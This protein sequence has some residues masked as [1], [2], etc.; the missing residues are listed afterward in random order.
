MG[1]EGAPFLVDF[2]PRAKRL[3]ADMIVVLCPK[4]GTACQESHVM[5]ARV[6]PCGTFELLTSGAWARALGYPPEELSG[7][8]LRELI[9][10]EKSTTAAVVAELL[11]TSAATPLEVTLRCKDELRKSFRLHRR[12]DPHGEAIFIVADEL[13]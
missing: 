4:P 10:L 9:V 1:Y 5:L 2:A 3:P 11:D 8:W 6:R 13:S 7:K 12:F